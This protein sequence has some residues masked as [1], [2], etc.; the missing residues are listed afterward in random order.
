VEFSSSDASAFMGAEEVNY[1]DFISIGDVDEEMVRMSTFGIYWS[2]LFEGSAVEENT[3][4][5]PN[6]ESLWEAG[7]ART[8]TRVHVHHVLR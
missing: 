3:E 2:R 8:Q 1:L 7:G 5:G 4:R 6:R